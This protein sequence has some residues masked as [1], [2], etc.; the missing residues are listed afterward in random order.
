MSIS[1]FQLQLLR[2]MLW[3]NRFRCRNP[4]ERVSG[5]IFTGILRLFVGFFQKF[6]VCLFLICLL[7]GISEVMYSRQQSI[8]KSKME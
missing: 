7:S 3:G 4:E 6:V 8:G 1:V 2:L 5:R